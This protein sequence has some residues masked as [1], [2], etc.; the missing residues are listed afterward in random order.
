MK[1]GRMDTEGRQASRQ[2]RPLQLEAG[3]SRRKDAHRARLRTWPDAADRLRPSGTALAGA[4]G[5]QPLAHREMEDAARP[6]VSR[7]GRLAGGL[8]VCRSARCLT[9]L[10]PPIRTSWR[11]IL[12]HLAGNSRTRAS[13]RFA[14][15]PPS[16]WQAPA[17]SRDQARAHSRRRWCA[18]GP[19]RAGA[20]H[21]HPAKSGPR[22]PWRC[23]PASS[24]CSCRR[25]K[26]S[27]SIV[28]TDQ[29][30]GA[31][32]RQTSL[33]VQ[34]EGYAPPHD[35]RINVI[36]VAPDPGVIEVNIHP[37]SSWREAVDI[38]STDYE[39]A[40]QT[41]LGADKFMIDGRHAVPAAATWSSSAARRHRTARPAAA[42]SSEEPGSLLAA[43][44][45]AVL[46]VLR[47][48]HRA[49]Q[50][51]AAYRRSAPRFSLRTGDRAGA[52]ADAGAG[53]RPAAVA[54]R[55]SL[56]PTS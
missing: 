7:A 36:R 21:E 55:P 9:C 47:P 4:C 56:P 23:A 18:P 30:S 31:A 22:S 20:R 24:A 41:R 50:P 37:A 5:R 14:A 38:T 17:D 35:A 44:P 52:G 53:H 27:K 1:T 39:E 45:G 43:A 34:I 46:P 15:A 29:C 33:P 49:D 11:A 16:A 8:T 32:A 2:R 13:R 42:R 40:R 10:R 28:G 19:R 25:W 48:L 51:G 3:R 54:G 12:Q 26:P 6:A